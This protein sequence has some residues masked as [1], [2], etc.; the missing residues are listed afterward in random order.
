MIINKIIELK[1]LKYINKEVAKRSTLSSG[2]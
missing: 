2:K 1:K